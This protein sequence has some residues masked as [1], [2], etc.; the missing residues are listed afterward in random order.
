MA[1]FDLAAFYTEIPQRLVDSQ[2]LLER[3]ITA[4][5]EAADEEAMATLNYR[6]KKGEIIDGLLGAKMPATVILEVARGRC[7]EEKRDLLLATSKKNKLHKLI[8]GYRERI[9]TLRHMGRGTEAMIR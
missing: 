5:G 8:E 4:Y 9:F 3:T 1:E 6:K 2:R 7:A